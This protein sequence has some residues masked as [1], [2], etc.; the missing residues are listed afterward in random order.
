MTETVEE[1]GNN[2]TFQGV[3]INEHGL[4][5]KPAYNWSE[6]STSCEDVFIEGYNPVSSIGLL[7]KEFS[8]SNKSKLLFLC[9]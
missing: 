2:S 3:V 5:C 7:M 9:R 1:I 4:L 8:T 6:N